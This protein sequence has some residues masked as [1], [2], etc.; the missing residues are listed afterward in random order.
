MT[1]KEGKINKIEQL[2]SKKVDPK[3]E[4]ATFLTQVVE[5]YNTETGK[6]I[7]ELIDECG[8]ED[9]I[10][11]ILIETETDDDGGIIAMSGFYYQLLLTVDYIIQMLEGKWSKVII[12]HHQD[13]IVYNSDTVR[14][15][16]VKTK[17]DTFCNVTD[18]KAHSEWIPKLISTQKILNDP[19]LDVKIEFELISNCTFTK[20]IQKCQDF[21][22]YYKNTYFDSSFNDKDKSLYKHVSEKSSKYNLTDDEI[23][24][25]LRTF[26]MTSRTPDDLKNNLYKRIA[27]QFND[28]SIAN[29]KIINM[30]ISFL[31]E[32]CFNPSDVSFQIVDDDSLI[33]LKADI[34]AEFQ[35]NGEKN[36]QQ[37]NMVEILGDFIEVL[38]NDFSGKT[39]SDEFNKIID[40]LEGEI[41]CFINESTNENLITILSRY[42]KRIRFSSYFRMNNNIARETE[43]KRIL[44]ILLLIKIFLNGNI[45]IDN[46]HTGLLL[47]NCDN[48]VDQKCTSFNLFGVEGDFDFLFE[49]VIIQFQNA[50]KDF[51]IEDQF[52]FINNPNFRVILSGAYDNLDTN[53]L[54][55]I[56]VE[57][58]EKPKVNFDVSD[59]ESN[60]SD[61]SIA[62]T[63]KKIFYIEGHDEKVTNI[64]KMRNRYKDID[65]IKENIKREFKL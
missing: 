63:N 44:N 23:K 60:E 39:Y 16:Q 5:K 65:E 37:D 15:I 7:E 17:N 11:K 3:G 24:K 54:E 29:D 31:F 10:E 40:S 13:I 20:G 52:S 38:R 48:D 62:V 25:G 26:R 32:K 57:Y 4:P 55:Y 50:F 28:Y 46:E 42:L 35:K 14:I 53:D 19:L 45:Q 49:D 2:I 36:I 56:E 22:N 61:T 43:F 6:T 21:E 9:R 59:D 41:V 58:K 47:V 64:R 1:K 30:I 8:K 18:S 51:S 27:K 33:D 12:D 34:S